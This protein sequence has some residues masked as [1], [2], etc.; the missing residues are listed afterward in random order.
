MEYLSLARKIQ[1]ITDFDSST[2]RDV[3]D[4][5]TSGTDDFTLGNFRFITKNEIDRIQQDELASDTYALGCFDAHF[6]GSILG[7]DADVV[8]R[9]QNAD[10]H[11]AV[12]MLVES[13][14]KLEEVQQ[15]YANANGYG[16]HFNTY[17]GSEY[18]AGDYYIFDN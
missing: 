18:E 9:M 6:L 4:E 13:S 8:T 17:D 16:Q 14:G 12:G 11:E 3:L 7:I 2:T 5:I 1:K 10:L 15:G